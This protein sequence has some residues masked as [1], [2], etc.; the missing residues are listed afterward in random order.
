[1]HVRADKHAL[2]II[3]IHKLRLLVI[4]FSYEICIDILFVDDLLTGF[5]VLQCLESITL[6]GLMRF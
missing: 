1:M 3:M 4:F 5:G 6:Q 2:C